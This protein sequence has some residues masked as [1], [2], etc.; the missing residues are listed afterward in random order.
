MLRLSTSASI[1]PP[2][3]S[4]TGSPTASQGAALLRRHLLRQAL[5]P[6]RHRAGDRRGGARHGRRDAQPPEVPAPHVRRQGLDP[7][8]D[9]RGGERAHAPDDLH[10]GRTADAVRAL[11][12]V[13]AQWVFYLFFFGLYLVSLEDRAPGRRLFRGRGGDQLHALSR[14]D[15]RRP[16]PR[17]CRRPQIAKHYWNLPADARRC[18]TSSL[19]V[20]ADEAHHRDVNHGFA[21]EL[22]GV[23]VDEAK[24]APSPYHE[25]GIKIAA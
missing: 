21:N 22:G 23:A 8:A 25:T 15:R 14:G 12:V 16:R 20:R 4:P 17:T 7:D 1:T 3:A 13:G 11:V 5:R 9:G 10:R 18:A 24:I 6:P 2:G 19:V